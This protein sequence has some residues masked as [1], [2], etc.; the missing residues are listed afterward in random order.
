[1]IKVVDEIPVSED[2]QI[3]VKLVNPALKIPSGSGGGS[4]GGD[5]NTLDAAG[6]S[7]GSKTSKRLSSLL[8]SSTLK[9]H[10]SGVSQGGTP[11]VDDVVGSTVG[12]NVKVSNGVV[13]VWE[14]ADDP[15]VDVDAL[16]KDGKIGWLCEVGAGEKVNLVLQWEVSSKVQVQGL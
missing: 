2:A 13:A 1:M 6:A 4:G 5:N 14:G 3:T 7:S 11:S 9:A 8:S 15:D 10:D 16:G 12:P